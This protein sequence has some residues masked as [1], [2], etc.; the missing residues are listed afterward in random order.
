MKT[1][2]R[3]LNWLLPN[4][5]LS[6]HCEVRAPAKLCHTCKNDIELLSFNR[7]S[8]LLHRPDIAK[9]FVQPSFDELLTASWYVDPIASWLKQL[10]FE[11]KLI[12]KEAIQQ[13]LKQQL[14][15][16]RRLSNWQ[17]PELY[18]TVP[19]HWV[20]QLQRGYNQ[21]EQIWQFLSPLQTNIICRQRPTKAQSEL[22]KKSRKSNISG[23][24][25][26]NLQ[27][28]YKHVAILDDIITT[29]STVNEIAK[30]LKSNGAETVSVWTA[31]ITP[32][33]KT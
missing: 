22:N 28:Q 25:R 6:C 24:F 5:C 33:N 8:N 12:Y 15:N 7:S 17:E 32:A 13:L 31:A 23:A 30:L 20:R 4:Q 14:R 11:N 2:N 29:G 27:Q 19:L 26:Y 1:T 18:V 16:A 21:S 3:L 10:K 9:L